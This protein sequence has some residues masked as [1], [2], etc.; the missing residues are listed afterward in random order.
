ME[1]KDILYDQAYDITICGP[2]YVTVALTLA[3]IVRM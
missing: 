2:L 1:N 3:L